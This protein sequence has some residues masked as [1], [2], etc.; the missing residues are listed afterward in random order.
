MKSRELS[1]LARVPEEGSVRARAPRERAGVM[2]AAREFE[3]PASESG[4]RSELGVG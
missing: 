2:L 1:G 4:E 3:R